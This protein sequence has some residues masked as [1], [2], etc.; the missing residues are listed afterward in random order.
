MSKKYQVELCKPAA[1]YAVAEVLAESPEQARTLALE[2]NESDLDWDCSDPGGDT[3][4]INV[5]ECGENSWSTI[6]EELASLSQKCGYPPED[7]LRK[8]VE[9]WE[10][11]PVFRKMLHEAVDA[12]RRRKA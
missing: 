11:D 5:E 2:M 12:D 10:V 6:S 4:V 3:K 8:F 1:N 9:L 7:I